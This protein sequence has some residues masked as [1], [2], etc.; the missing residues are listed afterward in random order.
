MEAMRKSKANSLPMV[1]LCMLILVIMAGCVPA[2]FRAHPQ[3]QEKVQSIKTV[4]IMP[5]SV[6]VYQL[7]VGGGTQ[8]MDEETVAATQIVA[9]A[10]EKELGRHAG[11]VFKP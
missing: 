8:L 6:K 4:A 5:P 3:L 7:A 10:I 1:F 11:V 9:G 2:H